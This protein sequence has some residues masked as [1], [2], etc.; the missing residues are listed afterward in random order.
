MPYVSDAQRK[1]FHALLN[2]GEISKKVVD[3]YDKASKGKEL[4]EHIKARK[5]AL[6]KYKK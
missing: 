4:P 6:E 3:E 1:K 2:R 5:K